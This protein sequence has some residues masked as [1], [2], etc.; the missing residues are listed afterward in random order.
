M[1]SYHLIDVLKMRV[2]TK[3]FLLFLCKT[4]LLSLGFDFAHVHEDRSCTNDLPP[5]PTDIL[6]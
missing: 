6:I 2:V 1:D 3:A 4:C 5:D